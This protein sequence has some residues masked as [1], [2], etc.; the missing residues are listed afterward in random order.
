LYISSW[1]EDNICTYYFF[2][3]DTLEDK[4]YGTFTGATITDNSTLKTALQELETAV[5]SA[6]GSGIDNVVEDLTPQL[7]GDLD[8]NGKEIIGTN[9]IFDPT[10]NVQIDLNDDAGG[11]K[12]SIRNIDPVEVFAVDSNGD[13]TLAGTVD[14]IDV[15]T[16][17]AAN[18]LKVSNATHTGDVTG[19]TALTIGAKK[20]TLGM[21]ADG[22]DGEL[23]T[24]D[25]SGVAAKV[26]TG[27]SGQV[28][29]S[30]GPG[31]APTMQTQTST[32][33]PNSIPLG[34]VLSSGASFFING[35][36]GVY[37]AFDGSSDDRIFY[38]D[39][40][41]KSGNLYDGSD[42]ALK[43]HWRISSNGGGGDTVGWIVKYAIVKDGD[44]TTTTS[45][46]IPQNNIDVSSEIQDE[47]F[48]TT[49][50]TMTGV[51]GADTIMITLTRNAVGG[52]SDTYTGQAEILGLEFV[53]I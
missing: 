6:A 16:D 40:L 33:R 46:T 35:G 2:T 20:V 11:T 32:W 43:L 48:D 47:M 23:I 12:F 25:A 7:G 42:L 18:T 44:N 29:T 13:L 38:N 53:K 17:V 9:I 51:S 27:T 21:L 10:A 5:E 8:V 24:Y 3:P 28:L 4:T 19:A 39:T 26:A 31:A 50:G 15:G 49:L 52:A 22:V 30:N 41:N 45:T 14:G 34:G 1:I 37:L 36:A